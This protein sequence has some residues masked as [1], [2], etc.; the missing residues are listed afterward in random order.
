MLK[1]IKNFSFLKYFLERGMNKIIDTMDTKNEMIEFLNEEIKKA[2]RK[3]RYS[4]N[5]IDLLGNEVEYLK[6]KI[7]KFNVILKDEES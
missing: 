4:K 5:R 3:I 2:E 1:K 7:D 6:K